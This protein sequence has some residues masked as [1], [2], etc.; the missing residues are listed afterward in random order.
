MIHDM[1]P[2]GSRDK[3]PYEICKNQRPNL[4]FLRIFGCRIYTLPSH[5]RDA[6]V[7]VHARSGIF[8]GYKRSLRHAY[9]LDSETNKIKV[10]RH[11]AFDECM[12]D[13]DN[14]PPFA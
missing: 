3:S 14:P 4:S 7:D 5:D 12:R 1:V 13:M 6:K 11:I 8:L 10:A 9:Y 2:H